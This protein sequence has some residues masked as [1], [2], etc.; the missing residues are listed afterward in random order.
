MQ[1]P[2]RK[3][4]KI[5]KKRITTGMRDSFGTF[6]CLRETQKKSFNTKIPFA[7]G[8]PKLQIPGPR[9]KKIMFKIKFYAR[10]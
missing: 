2:I 6:L 8:L 5:R 1:D 3:K 9:Q 7:G 4:K 10:N